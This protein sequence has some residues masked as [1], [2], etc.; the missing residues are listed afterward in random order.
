[1]SDLGGR[2]ELVDHRADDGTVIGSVTRRTMRRGNLMH[3]AVFIAV[4]NAAGELAVHRR[5]AWK[6]LWPSWWDLAFGG[7]LQAGESFDDG[8]RRELEEE[9][10]SRAPLEP[11]GSASYADDHVR[12]IA[13]IYLARDDGPFTFP[14]GEVAESAW[15]PLPELAS[16][17]ATRQV[18]PDSLAL[19]V[20]RLIP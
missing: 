8:A 13:H 4:V 10:G 3:G 20:P 19:V 15:V 17:T 2:E 11:L 14:D 18:C 16:W 9:T 7:V 12:E 1:V 5:A 6:D